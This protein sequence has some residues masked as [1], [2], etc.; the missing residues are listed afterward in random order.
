[1]INFKILNMM[2]STTTKLH[3]L[4]NT[5]SRN[6]KISI[7]KQIEICRAYRSGGA[8]G[9]GVAD[10]VAAVTLLMIGTTGRSRQR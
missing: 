6:G 4:I 9:G 10:D 8:G 2:I 7:A 1:M 5:N 3:A